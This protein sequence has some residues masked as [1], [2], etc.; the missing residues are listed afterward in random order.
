M[1]RLA[2]ILGLFFTNCI[3]F[4]NIAAVNFQNLPSDTDFNQQLSKFVENSM[5]I[6]VYTIKWEYPVSKDTVIAETKHFESTLSRINTNLSNIDLCLLH[7]ICL[8]YMYNLDIPQSNDKASAL[9]AMNRP[10]IAGDL[11]V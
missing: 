10:G 6:S 2:L 7:I 11:K 1:K 4:A 3:L 5:Y 8:N 9:I